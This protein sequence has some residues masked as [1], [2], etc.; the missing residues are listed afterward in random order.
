VAFSPDGRYVLSGGTE[1]A[2][3]LWDRHTGAPIREFVGS[4]AG[5]MTARFSPDGS[6]VLTT[7]GHPNPGAQLW[8]TETGEL[9]REFRWSSAWPMGAVF[10]PDGTKIATRSQGE[11]IRI[12]EAATGQLVRLLA[13]AGWGGPMAFAPDA[14]LLAA[15]AT[16]FNAELYN[17]ETGQRL[18]MF[19]ANAGAVT[20][21]A[22][23]P[24]GDTLMLGW[25]DGL[26]R[27]YDTTTLE[28]RREWF[29][30][31]AFLESAAYSPEGQHILTGEG[32]PFLTAT[33][34]DAQTGEPL[35]TFRGHK[36]A[37]TTVGFSADGRSILTGA[38]VVREWS[39]ADLAGRLRIEKG[40]GQI[41]LRWS[42]GELQQAASAAGPWQPLT[43]AVSPLM[44]P[45]GESM[46]FYRVVLAGE[47]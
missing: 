23:S 35:R 41:E 26:I 45:S 13:N 4:P 11:S 6:K 34:W 9:E 32:W 47:D 30:P 16:D 1:S 20:V 22:F 17:Y 21:A 25:V 39:I 31:A 40:A 27:L 10:S 8:K 37:V 18:H 29:T 24:K 15:A 38:E 3:R 2:T 36:W 7:A 14:P 12:F 28:M 19:S 42:S 43:N 33:L 46:G 5:T 44:I